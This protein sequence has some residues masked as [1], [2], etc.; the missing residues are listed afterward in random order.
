ML[1]AETRLPTPSRAEVSVLYGGDGGADVGAPRA[2]FAFGV[3]PAEQVVSRVAGVFGPEG[4]DFWKPSPQADQTVVGWVDGIGFAD[5]QHHF[6]ADYSGW[7]AAFGGRLR[8]CDQD[9]MLQTVGRHDLSFRRRGGD[10][11]GRASFLMHRQARFFLQRI[12]DSCV[13]HDAFGDPAVQ[14][15][16]SGSGFGAQLALRV[17]RLAM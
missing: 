7:L 16:Q 15:F 4:D 1:H 5:Q 12:G 17:L 8:I 2:F 3:D 14:L 13:S 6:A 10:R 9:R 11:N